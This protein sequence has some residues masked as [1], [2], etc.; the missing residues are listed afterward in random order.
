MSTTG[1]EDESDPGLAWR[2]LEEA[3]RELAQSSPASPD[4]QNSFQALRFP[5]S[6]ELRE[7]M[8]LIAESA[9]SP[10]LKASFEEL[11]RPGSPALGAQMHAVTNSA[12]LP[13]LGA[14]V[15]KLSREFRLSGDV[16][17]D[18]VWLNAHVR[19]V[20][21]GEAKP[22]PPAATSAPSEPPAPEAELPLPAPESMQGQESVEL[23]AIVLALHPWINDVMESSAAE[24]FRNSSWALALLLVVLMLRGEPD[25]N[26]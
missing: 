5:I 18:V 15:V 13:E 11:L 3:L 16:R 8:R 24:A 12:I 17:A 2:R 10:E 21:I 26:Q 7:Q 22:Y 6:P 9:I 20:L 4:L 14:R 25:A 19:G 1:S 23:A